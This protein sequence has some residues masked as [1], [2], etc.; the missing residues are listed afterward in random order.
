MRKARGLL[1]VLTLAVLCAPAYQ[2]NAVDCPGWR[3]EIIDTY[4]SDYFVTYAGSYAQYCCEENYYTDGTLDGAYKMRD[5]TG[6][7]GGTYQRTC[8]QKVSG[9]WSPITCP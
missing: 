9:S 2:V 6:C 7:I 8:Y 5:M 1:V 4:Y 3:H